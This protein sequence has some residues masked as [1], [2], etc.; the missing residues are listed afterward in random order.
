MGYHGVSH[1]EDPG[2]HPPGV[3]AVVGVLGTLGTDHQLDGKARL[4]GRFAF[5]RNCLKQLQ[6]RRPLVPREVAARMDHVV[7]AQGREGDEV[8]DGRRSARMDGRELRH[9]GLEVAAQRG[10]HVLAPVDEVDL[11]HR[12][13][14]LAD[15]EQACHE[16]VAARLL[17][18]AVA[19]VH[20]ED[21]EVGVAGAGHHVAGVLH[22]PRSVGHDEL[23]A[24]GGEVAMGHVDGDALLALGAQA[25][26]QEGEVHRAVGKPVLGL[27]QSL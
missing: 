22:V 2:S 7:A 15:A 27:F 4:L 9:E 14:Q 24:R 17:L 5:D 1:R 23:A 11:V 18:D 10:E 12:H 21:G 20:Q 8:K 16:G 6:E 26:G 3:A 13:H 25:V 19:G